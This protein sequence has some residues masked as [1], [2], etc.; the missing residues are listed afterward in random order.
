M[1][2]HTPGP[3]EVRK[4]ENGHTS[5]YP[6]QGRERVADV[7]CPLDHPTGNLNANARLIAAA[8]EMLEALKLVDYMG[9][10]GMT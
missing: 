8:P 7:Y 10:G 4:A 2:K 6:I 3:W 1:T 9:R 5:V